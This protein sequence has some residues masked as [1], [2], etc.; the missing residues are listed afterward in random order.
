MRLGLGQLRCPQLLRCGRAP[1][2]PTPLSLEAAYARY[3]SLAEGAT[4][5]GALSLGPLRATHRQRFSKAMHF[6]TLRCAKSGLAIEAIL[7]GDTLAVEQARDKPFPFLASKAARR[8][9]AFSFQSGARRAS[10]FFFSFGPI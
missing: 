1:A 4:G 6:V 10:A 8:A 2:D 3:E 9:S 7:R 5:S